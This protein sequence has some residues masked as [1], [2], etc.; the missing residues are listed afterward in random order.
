MQIN[1]DCVKEGTLFF[2]VDGVCKSITQ[3]IEDKY[4]ELSGST[5]S[6][7]CCEKI[8]LYLSRLDYRLTQQDWILRKILECS[9]STSYHLG[10]SICHNSYPIK[11]KS[12]RTN[13]IYKG[14]YPKYIVELPEDTKPLNFKTYPIDYSIYGGFAIL[15]IPGTWRI[16]GNKI[17]DKSGVDLITYLPICFNYRVKAIN[18]V[19]IRGYAIK[20]DKPVLI[21]ET[22]NIL[23]KERK[24]FEAGNGLWEKFI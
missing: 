14:G 10:S 20:N 6:I 8:L 11:I 13:Y 9:C 22:L 18:M 16:D 21:Y 15:G 4:N 12:K 3:I 19:G 1:N 2:E 24:T 23:T 17:I 5:S 7:E